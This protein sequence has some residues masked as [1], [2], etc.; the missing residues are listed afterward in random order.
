MVS[1]MGKA[2]DAIL[3]RLTK[4]P[5][6]RSLWSRFPIGS[7]PTRVAYGIFRRPNYAYG[8]YS[9]AWLASRLNLPG[10][11]VIEFGVAAGSGLLA[12]EHIAQLV[13]KELGIQIAVFGF[14]SGKGMPP[15]VDY[16]D[17]PYVWGEGFYSMDQQALRARLAP[18][19]ELV[20]GDVR[21]TIPA[22]L[23]RAGAPPVGFVSFDLDYYSSTM[24]AFQIFEAPD[25]ARTLPRVYCYMDDIVWPKWACYNEFTGELRAI[26]DFNAAHEFKKLCP[27]HLLQWMRPHAQAWNQQIYILHDFR[28]PHYCTNITPASGQQHHL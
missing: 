25:P 22:F 4:I 28:H 15:P 24:A 7:V 23:N 19:T 27:E 5:G 12:L 18:S 2:A 26:A 3:P 21:D 13:A 14:D 8:V 17:L 9:A 10:I 11:S 20:I 6:V 1:E 16:R